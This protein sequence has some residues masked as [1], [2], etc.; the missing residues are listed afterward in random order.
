MT[1]EQFT[2]WLQ[3]FVEISDSTPT[4]A[5]WTIIKDHLTLVMN[6]QT[7]YRGI[8]PGVPHISPDLFKTPLVTC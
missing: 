3:G 5:Q 4:E 7:P 1:P 8:Q 6:K 2:Y